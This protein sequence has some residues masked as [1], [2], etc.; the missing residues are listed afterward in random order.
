M[1]K[2]KYYREYPEGHFDIWRDIELYY[3]RRG[4]LRDMDNGHDVPYRL[5]E[6]IEE[7]MVARGME[8]K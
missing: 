5:I 4:L 6:Q 8:V 7:E 2:K 1:K 3:Q